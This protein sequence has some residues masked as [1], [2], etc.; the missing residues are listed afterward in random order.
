MQKGE[1][2]THQ[3]MESNLCDEIAGN[4]TVYASMETATIGR[5]LLLDASNLPRTM[6]ATFQHIKDLIR[7][8]IVWYYRSKF[9]VIATGNQALLYPCKSY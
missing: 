5:R 2:E 9:G 8:T 1:T 3:Q 7:P 6:A 4:L